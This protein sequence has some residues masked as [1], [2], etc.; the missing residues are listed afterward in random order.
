[1]RVT[2]RGTNTLT[3]SQVEVPN[4]PTG[5]IPADCD[6]SDATALPVNAGAVTTITATCPFGPT[7]VTGDAA[8]SMIYDLLVTETLRG[9]RVPYTVDFQVDGVTVPELSGVM[10][11]VENAANVPGVLATRRNFRFTNDG[12]RNNVGDTELSPAPS[13]E[14]LRIVV[15]R[16]TTGPMGDTYDLVASLQPNDI[17]NEASTACFSTTSGTPAATSTVTC[18]F[19]ADV[20]GGSPDYQFTLTVTD[21]AGDDSDGYMIT[22]FLNSVQISS[23]MVEN[24]PSIVGGAGATGTVVYNYRIDNPTGPLIPY[25]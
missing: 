17:N 20:S 24:S 12:M 18:P 1:M 8:T 11:P 16:L 3:I 5:G 4:L 6:L 10:Q 7:V 19:F 9:G 14:F 23:E 13:E 15:E 25:P 22:T 21:V 2:W